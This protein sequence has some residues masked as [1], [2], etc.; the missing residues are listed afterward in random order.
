LVPAIEGA[1]GVDR[2]VLVEEFIRGMEVTCGVLENFQDKDVAALPVTEIR[3][4]GGND[5]FNYHAKYKNGGAEEITPAPIDDLLREKIQETAVRAHQILG[6]SG[7][8]RTD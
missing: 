7:Y 8:S 2:K 1:F 3:P 4:A 5:F 6:C